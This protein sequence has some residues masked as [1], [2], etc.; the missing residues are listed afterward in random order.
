MQRAMLARFAPTAIIFITV[1]PLTHGSVRRFRHGKGRLMNLQDKKQ[2]LLAS[3]EQLR[4]RQQQLQTELTQRE[5]QEQQT[6][7]ALM[8]LEELMQEEKPAE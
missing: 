2:Q 3:L 4:I 1:P 6:I 8:L 7:G 5:A